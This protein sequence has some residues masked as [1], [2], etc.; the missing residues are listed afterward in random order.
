MTNVIDLQIKVNDTPAQRRADI[1][2]TLVAALPRVPETLRECVPDAAL[3]IVST[4]VDSPE[5]AG[6]PWEGAASLLLES[7]TRVDIQPTSTVTLDSGTKV[8][9]IDRDYYA[10][11]FDAEMARGTFCRTSGM[12]WA[13]W[14]RHEPGTVVCL[15]CSHY[16]FFGARRVRV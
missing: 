4:Q 9:I 1:E 15:L 6:T 11:H 3:V 12:D 13:D 16:H 8:R 2:Q 14:L 10:A 7:V 5:D